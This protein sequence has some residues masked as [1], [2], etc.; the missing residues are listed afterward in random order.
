VIDFG[1]ARRET[2]EMT[3]TAEGQVLG[4]PA[5]MSPE[6]ARGEGHRADR[7]SD[8]YSL[9][10][11]LFELLTGELPF[12][13]EA[14]M[15]IV[16]ILKED[17]PGPR[18]LNAGIPRD[19]ETITLKCLEKD[20]AKRYQTAEGLADDLKRYLSGEPIHA[21]AVGGAERAWRWCRRNRTVAISGMVVA[22]VLAL[23]TA[24]STYYAIAASARTREAIAALKDKDAALATARK[25]VDQMLTRTADE[26]LSDVPLTQPLRQ[27]LLQDALKFYEGFIAQAENDPTL[28]LEM[29]RTLTK[30]GD[31]QRDISRYDDAQHSYQRSIDLLEQLLTTTP[32][33][34]TYRQQLALAEQSLGWLMQSRATNPDSHEAE[35]RY[36]KVQQILT[37]LERDFPDRIQ[38]VVLPLHQLAD[39]ASRRGDK[40]GGDQ[41][42]REA[43]ANG[44][45]YVT[46]QPDDAEV[47][48]QLC[49]CYNSLASTSDSLTDG[50]TALQKGLQHTAILLQQHPRSSSARYADAYLRITL[51]M[52]YYLANRHD[53][54]LPL[55]QKGLSE[56]ESAIAA[57]PANHR[58]WIG[59]ATVNATIAEELKRSERLKESESLKS[60][61]HQMDDWLVET[62][63]RVPDDPTL[64]GDLLNCQLQV[65]DLLRST[66]QK[67][68]ADELSRAIA[69]LRTKLETLDSAKEGA[70]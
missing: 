66:G 23:G 21:R 67:R 48:V 62:A 1:L 24:V 51:G 32:G 49:W 11:I 8:I 59:L 47:R 16:Q 53:E 56:F 5:Y 50:E 34:F 13:G 54:A 58:L 68:E 31:I 45:R 41:L 20:P 36:R 22:V 35:A 2:G 3:M 10:V 64:L 29:A 61:V 9:G 30:V 52:L 33:D 14:R 43:I 63:P 37:G 55:F 12:R 38:P 65:A 28:R 17:P 7:R 69:V 39:L 25:A 44:E 18:K 40:A 6:Q 26:T 60:L 4:T 70:K 57:S 15:L 42:L 46:Q 27:A 19:M